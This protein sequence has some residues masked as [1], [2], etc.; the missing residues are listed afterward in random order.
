MSCFLPENQIIS[1]LQTYTESTLGELDSIAGTSDA[2]RVGLRDVQSWDPGTLKEEIRTLLE[3]DRG[4]DELLGRVV[5]SPPSLTSFLHTYLVEFCMN[6]S[7]INRE[8]FTWGHGDRTNFHRT[9]LTRTIRRLGLEPVDPGES[10][11]GRVDPMSTSTRSSNVH[12]IRP[13]DSVSCSPHDTGGPWAPGRGREDPSRRAGPRVYPTDG[14]RAYRTRE[15]LSARDMQ[16][17]A[18]RGPQSV[19][20]LASVP[21]SFDDGEKSQ[22]SRGYTTGGDGADT[23][24][25]A[26]ATVTTDKKPPDNEKSFSIISQPHSQI[27]KSVVRGDTTSRVSTTSGKTMNFSKLSTA[28][29][30]SGHRPKFPSVTGGA[31]GGNVSGVSMVR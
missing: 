9:I 6:N 15:S 1:A 22:P 30:E 23:T 10:S 29:Y 27:N 2:W 14:A 28:N 12:T 19:A 20:P 26:D 17:V 13:S 16:S 3:I 11:R 18:S 8:C 4:F 24:D 31:G 21:D 7:V 25:P 5:K